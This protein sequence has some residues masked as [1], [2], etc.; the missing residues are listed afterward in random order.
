MHDEKDLSRRWITRTVAVSH[1]D[2]SGQLVCDLLGMRRR[3]VVVRVHTV[4]FTVLRVVVA[5]FAVVVSSILLIAVGF[6]VDILNV[7]VI[8]DRLRVGEYDAVFSIGTAFG[9]ALAFSPGRFC[10]LNL[11][12][13]SDCNRAD[14]PGQ[15]K[16]G[17]CS[18]AW[19]RHVHPLGFVTANEV[20]HAVHANYVSA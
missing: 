4:V 2:W 5:A 14:R 12:R 18:A 9:L 1:S 6:N 10:R 11:G 7:R 3:V 19:T 16:G 20:R 17:A 8:D 13:N 15:R